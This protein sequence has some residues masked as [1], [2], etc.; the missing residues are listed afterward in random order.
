MRKKR[1][2]RL[3][4]RCRDV[5]V[6]QEQGRFSVLDIASNFSMHKNNRTF[7]I[8]TYVSEIDFR[9][10]NISEIEVSSNRYIGNRSFE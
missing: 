6:L 5:L 9:L 1:L 4:A 3:T 2:A 8:S 7:D 10:I